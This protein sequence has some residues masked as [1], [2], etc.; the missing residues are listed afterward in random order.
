M[1]SRGAFLARPFLAL[2]RLVTQVH[3]LPLH[4]LVLTLKF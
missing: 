2:L 4:S 1:F 3:S